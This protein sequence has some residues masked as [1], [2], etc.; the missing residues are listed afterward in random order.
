MQPAC[1][2]L[3]QV[4]DELCRVLSARAGE[5]LEPGEQLLIGEFALARSL[6]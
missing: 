6:G 5:M 2:D 1:F 3:A 4:R